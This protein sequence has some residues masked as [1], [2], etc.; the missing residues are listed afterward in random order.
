MTEEDK[1]YLNGKIYKIINSV[2]DKCY[3]GS[4]ICALDKRLSGHKNSI[5]KATSKILINE[6]PDNV[7]IKLIEEYPCLTKN[8]LLLRERYWTDELECVN[9]FRPIRTREEK[10]ECNR[11]CYHKN[12]ERNTA[13][14]NQRIQCCHCDK[15]YSRS[16]KNQHYRRNH[17]QFDPPKYV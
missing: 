16:N 12:R 4:T 10:L 17:S 7:S 11:N 9:K 8:E 14:F 5:L 13:R 1:K 6:D 3:V 15:Q 2:N